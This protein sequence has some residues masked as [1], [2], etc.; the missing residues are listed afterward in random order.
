MTIRTAQPEDFERIKTLYREVARRDG[1]LARLEH[2]ITDKY[3]KEFLDKSLERGLIIVA[4]HEENSEILIGE[5]HAYRPGIEVFKHVLSNLTITVHPD[6]QGKKIGRTIF[7]I[8]LEEIGLNMHD[9]GR[10]E[11]VARESNAKAIGLY[12]SLGF[13]ID[14]RFEMRIRTPD[15]NYEAD[16]PM[17]WQN[18]NFEFD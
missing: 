3:V 8:F 7:T 5:I 1:G 17:S 10:V 13:T 2:E 9:I 18:P 14:G 6:F 16:I 15:G 4:E 12:Q 11:L